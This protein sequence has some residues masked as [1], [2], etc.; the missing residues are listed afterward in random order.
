M[1]ERLSWHARIVAAAVFV[2]V[3]GT[4][5][6]AT[7]SM[8]GSTP[9]RVGGSASGVVHPLT[10]GIGS[11]LPGTWWDEINGANSAVF[12]G[13]L[14]VNPATGDAES[15]VLQA[16]LAA[17]EV[18]S[19]NMTPNDNATDFGLEFFGPDAFGID[20][21]T[22]LA[23]SGPLFLNGGSGH[24]RSITSFLVPKTGL[25]YFHVYTWIDG[26][27]NGGSGAYSLSAT[28]EKVETQVQV[29]PLS[30][31]PY[32]STVTISGIVHSRDDN[33]I[34]GTITLLSS[35]SGTYYQPL[36]SHP[37]A[38]GS[39]S[40]DVPAMTQTMH[41]LVQYGGT[42]FYNP[43]AAPVNV[44]MTAYLSAPTAKRNAT[45]TYTLSGAIGSWHHSDSSSVRI[46]LWHSVHGKWKASGYRTAAIAGY[47]VLQPYSVKYKF[48]S[49][50]KWRLQAYH[51]DANHATTR[52]GYTNLTVK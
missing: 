34:S 33:G 43:S 29:F 11:D 50:G 51:S 39:F 10:V 38:D 3:V 8:L 40:F 5:S 47:F 20:Y 13:D 9:A 16:Y 44:A 49:T 37:S 42:S 30:T 18:I 35:E 1:G 52:S 2:A 28:F 21:D 46:Y 25:Y 48:P 31:V 17:G 4:A 36:A 12:N 27:N 7:A 32:Y 14:I 22:P 45:R 24:V 41:Y 26:A 23:A 19:I 6:L 15:D